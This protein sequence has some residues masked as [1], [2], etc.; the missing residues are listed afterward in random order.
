MHSVPFLPAALLYL[1]SEPEFEP[2]YVALSIARDGKQCFVFCAS[3][4]EEKKPE[5]SCHAGDCS[6]LLTHSRHPS[7]SCPDT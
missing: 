3:Q 6:P 7:K 2:G 4:G 5:V 1:L